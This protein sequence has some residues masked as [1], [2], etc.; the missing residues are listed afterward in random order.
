MV[1]SPAHIGVIIRRV[2]RDEAGERA[3]G[4]GILLRLHLGDG[5]IEQHLP[6]FGRIAQTRFIIGYGSL[7]I[8]A[9]LP[10][11]TAHLIGIDNERIPLD[12]FGGIFFGTAEIFEAQLGDRTVEI[13]FGQ[14]GFHLYDAVEI[15]NGQHIIFEIECIAPDVGNTLGIELR[16]SRPES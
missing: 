12:G 2:Q 9:V 7:V 1:L 6:V 15:L 11:D 8:T 13:G 16:H 3:V 10:G 14:I 5:L 4:P